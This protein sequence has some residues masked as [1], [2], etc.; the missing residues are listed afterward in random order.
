MKRCTRRM[1][2]RKVKYIVGIDEAGRGPLAG[3]LTVAAV[4]WRQVYDHRKFFAGV[5]DSKQLSMH[6][7]DF[8]YA[9]LRAEKQAGNLMYSVSFIMPSGIDRYGLTSVL[10]RGVASVLRRLGIAA[11]DA[12]V[13]LD[14]SLYAPADYLQETIIRGDEMVPIISLASVV[15][16]VKRDKRMIE[17]ARKYPEYGFEQHKGY[18][19]PAHYA[20]IRKYGLCDIHRRRFLKKFDKRK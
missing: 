10:R 13:M 19:V 2:N 6:K 11:R 1:T 18:G 17:L 16:K 15:A 3:P 12:H 20:A 9:A 7:R 8:F 14:G 5:R 4:A